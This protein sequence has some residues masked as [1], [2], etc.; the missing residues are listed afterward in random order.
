MHVPTRPANPRTKLD[1]KMVYFS[2]KLPILEGVGLAVVSG[3]LGSEGT[4]NSLMARLFCGVRW[5]R[6]TA[7]LNEPK[8]V[9]E[10]AAALAREIHRRGQALARRRGDGEG[11][12]SLTVHAQTGQVRP[13]LDEDGGVD[14]PRH[15]VH[16]LDVRRI[17]DC[18]MAETVLH[19]LGHGN[20]LDGGGDAY[21]R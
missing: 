3:S 5:K 17:H 4:S 6:S 13:V 19:A 16:V 18:R 21:D 7:P 14:G 10:R 11:R 8:R 2:I 20:G 1:R 15:R 12:V 9:F